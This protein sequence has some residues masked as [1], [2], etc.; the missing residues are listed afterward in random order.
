MELPRENLCYHQTFIDVFSSF[1]DTLFTLCILYKTPF[2]G[3]VLKQTALS[4]RNT[5]TADFS[6]NGFH[7][8]NATLLLFICSHFS[9]QKL[10]TQVT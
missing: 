6:F 10:K 8:A 9:L 1:K 5:C 2:P 3:S 4:K 7:I